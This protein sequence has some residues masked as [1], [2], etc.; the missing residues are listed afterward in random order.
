M[1][2]SQRRQAYL[3]RIVTMTWKPAGM[4]SSRPAFAIGLEPMAPR[5]LTFADL[6]Q[7][8]AAAEA[9]IVL[10]L[11]HLFDALAM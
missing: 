2:A 6:H 9:D 11:D 4:I 1:P 10:R 7:V 3:G 8:S 5:W